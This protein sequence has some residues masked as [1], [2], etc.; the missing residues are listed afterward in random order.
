[1]TK[2]THRRGWPV[3]LMAAA[4]LL[5]ACDRKATELGQGGSVVSGSAGPAGAHQA[6]KELL[7]CDAPVATLALAEN[8]QGYTYA[9]SYQLP[10][11]PLPLVRLMAQQS[12]CFRVVDRSAGLR[13]TLQEQQLRDQGERLRDLQRTLNRVIDDNTRL[14]AARSEGAA[15]GGECTAVAC[16]PP[17]K[18]GRPVTHW[19][20]LC[21]GVPGPRRGRAIVRSSP[22]RRTRRGS[23]SPVP[24]GRRSRP[25]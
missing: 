6:A 4:T 22:T 12:N 11:T 10:P 8:P 2:T 24:H 7:H 1:M 15:V 17:E 21:I 14:R 19:A 13:G 23:P 16:E 9:G 25:G 18:C 5:A 20:K 3:L